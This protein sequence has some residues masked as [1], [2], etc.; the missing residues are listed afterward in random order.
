M[1]FYF[2]NYF[3]NNEERKAASP[4]YGK[5]YAN[6]PTTFII[7]AEFDPLSVEAKAYCDKLQEQ[8]VESEFTQIDGV[9]HSFLMLENLCKKECEQ[10]YNAISEFLNRY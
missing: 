5:F 2:S 3:T 6:M 8:N 10:T 7:T 4:L 9:T 1:K